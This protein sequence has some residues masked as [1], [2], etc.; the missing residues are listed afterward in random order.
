MAREPGGHGARR[1]SGRDGDKRERQCPAAVR[2]PTLGITSTP[3]IDAD[4]NTMYVVAFSEERRETR[5]S[6][7]CARHHN[8]E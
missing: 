8:G 5:K 7:S 2:H 6:S 3:V 4:T 1:A